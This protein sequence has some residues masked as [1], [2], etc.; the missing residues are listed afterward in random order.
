MRT[1]NVF[2]LLIISSTAQAS[3]W[4]SIGKADDG[5]SETFVDVSDIHVAGDIRR[6]WVRRVS[7]NTSKTMY[8]EAFDCGNETSRSE[9]IDIYAPDGSVTSMPE[10]ML[11]TTWRPIRPDTTWHVAMTFICNWHQ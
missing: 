7:T 11:S 6:T 10:N 3:Q 5:K 2:A 4:I 9:A 1:I 8:R